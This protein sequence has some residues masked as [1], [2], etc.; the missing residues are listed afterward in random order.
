MPDAKND[1]MSDLL[2]TYSVEV[3]SRDTASLKAVISQLRPGT[4]VFVANLPRET[5]DVLVNAC[6]ELRQAGLEPVPH[7]VAR[8]IASRAA[9]DDM[10]ARLTG[11]A[12]VKTVLS[13]AGD[14][15]DPAGE[16]DASLQ[17]IRTGLYAK[18]G[19]G[20]VCISAYPEGHPR[21]ADELLN[22]AMADKLA[23]LRDAGHEP[24]L[25][26]QFLF[27]AGRIVAFARELRARGIDTPFR[28]GVAGPAE[29]GKLIKYA[30]RCGVGA[31]L[32]ALKERSELAKSVMSG[33]TPE[34]LLG[35]VAAAQAAEPSLGIEGV[36]FF[37][38]GDPGSSVRW[39]E[40]FRKAVT[41]SRHSFA[42]AAG[43]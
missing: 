36:H 20:R 14:R 1:A 9:L 27:D 29:R 39:A 31:S 11:E 37:T 41:P 18:H 26:G 32:R 38:F 34:D 19:I 6:A 42:A 4:E 28:V 13:L 3:T 25:V 17:L 24:L 8:N 30:L 12:G 21:I 22:Q 7:I 43:A 5:A 16:F 35:E 33:E 2:E 23:A 10:L 40:S 15:D